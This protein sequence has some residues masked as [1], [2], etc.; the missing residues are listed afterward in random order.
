MS[1]ERATESIDRSTL[2][3]TIKRIATQPVELITLADYW[4]DAVDERLA[5]F[6]G[7]LDNVKRASA[8]LT[9][10]RVNE[11]LRRA[12]AAGVKLSLS[13]RSGSLVSSGWR[14]AAINARTSGAA[15]KSKHVRCQALDVYDPAGHLDD[16]CMANQ[17]VLAEIGLWLEHPGSTPGWSHVQT[18]PPGSGRRVF[19]P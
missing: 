8:T 5:R 3:K 15:A 9:V 11:L 12:S 17:P 1:I 7:E 19:H 13:P 18:L 6:G 4:M 14:P 2:S 10:A 16:W